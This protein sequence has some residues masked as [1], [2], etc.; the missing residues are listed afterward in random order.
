MTHDRTLP[1][2]DEMYTSRSGQDDYPT[3]VMLPDQDPPTV[4]ADQPVD[5]YGPT[6]SRGYDPGPAPGTATEIL[7]QPPSVLA[8]LAVKKGP[9]AGKLHRLAPDVTSIGRDSHNDIIIDDAA[10]SR[11]HAKLRLEKDKEGRPQFYIYDLA[12][13]NG[14]VVNGAKIARQAL[15][16]DDEI[17]IGRTIMVFKQIVDSEPTV[18]SAVGNGEE[19]APEGV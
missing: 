4:P 13:G 12:S 18:E 15:F 8:W 17:E 14:T 11:Q 2:G 10:V 6:P 1:I 16:N 7:H 19:P 9:R 5:P 3:D